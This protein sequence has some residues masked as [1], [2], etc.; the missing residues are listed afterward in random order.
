MRNEAA[1]AI[2]QTAAA[3]VDRAAANRQSLKL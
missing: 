2:Q 3:I 1:A